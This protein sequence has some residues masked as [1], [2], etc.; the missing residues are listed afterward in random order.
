MYTRLQGSK[1]SEKSGKVREF[2]W[3]GKVREKS[4]NFFDGPGKFAYV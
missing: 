2:V 4:G 1:R 3:S